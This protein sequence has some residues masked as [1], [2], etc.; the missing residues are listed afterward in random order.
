MGGGE[1]AREH[2]RYYKATNNPQF[3]SYV[4]VHFPLLN[5]KILNNAFFIFTFCN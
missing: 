5:M 3:H 4:G 2:H 1:G